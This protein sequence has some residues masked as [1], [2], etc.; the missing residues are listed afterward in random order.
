MAVHAAGLVGRG[1]V[2][3]AGER[4]RHIDFDFYTDARN[5]VPVLE[6]LIQRVASRW[7]WVHVDGTI[8]NHKA[9]MQARVP[10]LDDVLGGLMK[11]LDN[12]QFEQPPASATGPL[13]TRR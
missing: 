9:V 11:G 12:G 2:G 7:V 4:D 10:I 13:R 3:F 1:S 8:E 5:R 6:P